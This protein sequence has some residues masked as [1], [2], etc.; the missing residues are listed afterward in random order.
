MRDHLRR[1]GREELRNPR[2]AVAD[3]VLGQ[4]AR[5]PPDPMLA[6]AKEGAC[7][8]GLRKVV[9][10]RAL[11]VQRGT[12]QISAPDERPHSSRDVT[13]LIVVSCRQLQIVAGGERHERLGLAGPD[14]ERF[15]D[16]DVTAAIEAGPRDVEVTGGRRRDVHDVGMRAVEQVVDVAEGARD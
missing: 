13:E 3:D 7:V 2:D 8:A 10:I 14:R 15:L 12:A 5:Q 9:A 16:V 11:D 4:A 6:I 1:L